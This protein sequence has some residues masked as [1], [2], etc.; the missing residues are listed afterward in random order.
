MEGP[1]CRLFRSGESSRCVQLGSTPSG[2]DH[3]SALPD[4]LLLLILARLGCAATAARTSVLTHRWRGLWTSLAAL[5]FRDVPF[6]S[7]KQAFDALA[8]DDAVV[9][10]FDICVADEPRT[11]GRVSS[12]LADASW[13][14]PE[15]ISLAVPSGVGSLHDP[16]ELPFFDHATSI[17][18]SMG[19]Y[20]VELRVP[21]PPAG[22]GKC[23]FPALTTLFI[24]G[25]YAADGVTALFAHI[26]AGN[27]E[28]YSVPLSCS[29]TY[30]I[31]VH[32]AT[33]RELIVEERE[34][35]HVVDVAA[36]MLKQ[37]TMSF[38]AGNDLTLSVVAPMAAEVLW[39]CRYGY[40]EWLGYGWRTSFGDWV[41]EA[42]TL[43]TS[44][45]TETPSLLRIDAVTVSDLEQE[46]E[47]H[48]QLQVFADFSVLDLELH[49]P[50]F[51]V[52]GAIVL[53]LLGMHRIFPAVRSL[54]V[55]LIKPQHRHM[56]GLNGCDEDCSCEPRTGETKLSP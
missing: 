49:L 7:F 52:Y 15:E 39:C 44:S 53:Y 10:N 2:A 42:V 30:A 11:A 16:V 55:V 34:S 3:I 24:S 31:T 37:L 51:H 25:Y 40:S 4:D 27:G 23:L 29:Q 41:L 21:A 47:K 14:L 9:S 45:S 46:V 6:R 36:P 43:T 1:W 50:G 20:P 32:S 56:E 26:V 28:R 48:L 19:T 54:K 22:S 8:R 35:V 33:L 5:A 38:F 12:L 18:L 13:F 17:S